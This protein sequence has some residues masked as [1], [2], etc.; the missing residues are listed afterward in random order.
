LLSPNAGER[1]RVVPLGLGTPEI[2]IILAIAL[3]IL[4]PSKLPQLARALGES[5]REFR[6]ASSGV[7]EKE[8][9]NVVKE[10]QKDVQ[11]GATSEID[12]ETLKKIAE[13]LGVNAEGKSSEQLRKEIVEKAKEKNIV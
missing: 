6:K 11:M 1:G 10:L 7:L 9:M 12:D 13:K 5:I 2:L 4:G 8:E 3:L